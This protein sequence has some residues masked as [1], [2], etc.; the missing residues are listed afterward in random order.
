MERK[1]IT[2]LRNGPKNIAVEPFSDTRGDFS[3]IFQKTSFTEIFP[4]LPEMVQTNLVTGNRGAVRGFHGAVESKK[5]WKITS[6]IMGEVV[7]GF[8]DIRPS[9]PT[10]GEVAFHSGS[11]SG[12]ESIIIPPGIA[13]GIQFVNQGS[14]IIYSTNIE[15]KNQNEISISPISDTLIHFWPEEVILSEKDINS[16]SLSQLIE[17]RV[18]N[19]E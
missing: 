7:H 15:Y 11:G 3:M 12:I 10:F 14:T 16:R 9:S 13:Y 17:D 19:A 18:F 8:I 6:C 4:R 1:L 2:E 5:Q